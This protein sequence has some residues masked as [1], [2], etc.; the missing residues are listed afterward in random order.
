MQAGQMFKK[1]LIFIFHLISLSR[2][3]AVYLLYILLTLGRVTNL[4]DAGQL[5]FIFCYLF[6]PKK[7]K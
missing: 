2:F 1:K 4:S 3:T 7:M 6:L 5:F